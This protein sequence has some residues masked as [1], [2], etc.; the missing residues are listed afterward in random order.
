MFVL[1]NLMRALNCASKSAR[2]SNKNCDWLISAYFIREQSTSD[3]TFT[4]LENTVCFENLAECVGKLL[5]GASTVLY[6]VVKRLGTR[7]AL[8]KWRKTLDYVSCSSLHFFRALPFP[9][10]FTTEQSAVEAFLVV[11]YLYNS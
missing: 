10:C 2:S 11:K 1:F 4:P 5:D 8:K 6:S 9:T 7:R 3:A